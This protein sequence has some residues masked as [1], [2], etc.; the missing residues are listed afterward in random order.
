MNIIGK[1]YASTSEVCV[2][3]R[4]WE[5]SDALSSNFDFSFSTFWVITFAALV[6]SI[7]PCAIAVLLILLSSL[8][9]TTNKKQALKVGLLFCLGLYI[10]YLLAGFG[11]FSI[12]DFL[13]LQQYVDI[14]HWT[15]GSLAII[16]GLFNIKDFIWYGKGF[17]VEIPKS[18]RPL[19][20]RFL[21]N[22]TSP[23]GAFVAGFIIIL[24][25]LPCT[26]GPYLF[27]VGYLSTLSKVVV[28]PVLIYYNLIFI[29]PL[30]IIIGL[31]YWGRASVESTRKWKNRN[32]KILHLL[33]GLLLLGLG[34]WVILA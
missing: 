11:L 5:C 1:V 34:I 16:L 14:I 26:G 17:S 30:L 21:K 8:L 12:F 25:E 9:M 24:F 3:S 28:V 29:L 22:I 31:I 4:F 27:T 15:I 18:W 23:L 13:H 20:R 19:M 10:A 33:A 7:N 2:S 32:I 6:D